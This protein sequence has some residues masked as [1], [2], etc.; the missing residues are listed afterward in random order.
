[1][2][3]LDDDYLLETDA[4]RE[5]YATIEDRPIVDPHT[6]ADV[7]EIVDNDGWDDIWESKPLRT[8]TSGR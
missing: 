6:H 1:M 5:L 3:F 2:S 4:A 8:T 7:A